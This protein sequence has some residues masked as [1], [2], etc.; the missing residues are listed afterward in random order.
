MEQNVHVQLEMI[1]L[2][3]LFLSLGVFQHIVYKYYMYIHVCTQVNV[4]VVIPGRTPSQGGD[5]KMRNNS[6]DKQSA[7][8]NFDASKVLLLILTAITI[9]VNYHQ[10]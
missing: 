4:R 5:L 6:A 10:R 9:Q 1:L 2:I 3:Y 7:A 8:I